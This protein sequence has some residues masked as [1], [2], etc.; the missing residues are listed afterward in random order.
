M[1]SAIIP[2]RQPDN[3]LVDIA[4]IGLEASQGRLRGIG[5]I[6]ENKTCGE[7]TGSWLRTD[8]HNVST[9]PVDDDVMGTSNGKS[10]EQT[11]EISSWVE[12]LGLFFGGD[13]KNL[14]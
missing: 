14:A 13:L 9:I 1:L 7:F 8:G 5:N 2:V 3:V 12:C 11:S 4:I 10:L 6:D